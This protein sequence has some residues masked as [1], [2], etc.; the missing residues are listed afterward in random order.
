L[1]RQLYSR[2]VLYKYLNFPPAYEYQEYV[3]NIL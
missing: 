3:E 1:S 2:E